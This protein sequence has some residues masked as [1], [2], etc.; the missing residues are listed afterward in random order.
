MR[1]SPTGQTL[2]QSPQGEINRFGQG[3]G[4]R[5][6]R[7]LVSNPVRIIR[8]RD[9]FD[10]TDS[11]TPHAFYAQL[12]FHD[13]IWTDLYGSK[14]GGEPDPCSELRCQQH[15]VDAK[16]SQPG[17]VRGMA[18]GKERNGFFLKHTNRPVTIPWEIN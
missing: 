15:I 1:S 18:M 9:R 11:N 5:G 2:I 13:R 17:E 10:R 8:T 14:D 6:T 7:N 4:S 12:F 3:F 16:R